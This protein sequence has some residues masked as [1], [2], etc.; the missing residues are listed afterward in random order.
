MWIISTYDPKFQKKTMRKNIER[1]W[2]DNIIHI[3]KS[4]LFFLT[5]V[6][7]P[8]IFFTIILIILLTLVV[9]YIDVS[10]L[11]ITLVLI[12]IFWW[13][14]PLSRII[15]FYLDYKMDFIIVNPNML[16]RYNQQWFFKRISKTIELKDI[17]S[18]S[19]RKSG[20]LQSLFN[21]WT[22]VFLSEAGEM[23]DDKKERAWE[24]VFRYVH[25]PDKVNSEVNKM[26]LKN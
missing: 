10:W 12:L 7:I 13:I 17:R 14:V 25:H 3:T 22:L 26:L 4:K 6:L 19:V 20:F 2:E 18:T 9:M 21:D 1:Y 15:K 11:I 23:D 5:K 16:I 24:V 8:M